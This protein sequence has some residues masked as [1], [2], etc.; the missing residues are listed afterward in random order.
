MGCKPPDQEY[1]YELKRISKNQ[2]IWGG[3]YYN[4]GATPCYIIWDKKNGDNDNADCELAWTSFKTATR[5]VGY[6]WQGMI[7]ENMKEKEE[8]IHVCQK[9]VY[10][11]KWILEHYAK[12]GDLIFN[13]RWKCK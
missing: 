3:N 9:P 5:K 10:V 4:L 12:A 13:T 1:F 8:R 2:I 6:R 11:Y 7:Q